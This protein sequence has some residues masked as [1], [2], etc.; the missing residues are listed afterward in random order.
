MKFNIFHIVRRSVIF[1]KSAV[2]YQCLITALLSAVITGSLLIGNSVRDS[3][4]NSAAER[5]GKTGILVSSGVRYFNPSLSTRL[6]EKTSIDCVSL[7]ETNGFCQNFASGKTLINVR[8]FGIN[9][10]FFR[11]HEVDSI[12]IKQGEVAVNSMLAQQLGLKPGDD[13]ILRFKKISEIPSN[14][15]FAS[16]KEPEVSLV[17][18]VGTLLSPEQT[19]NFSLGINQIVPLNVFVNLSDLERNA[20]NE[21]KVNRLL[22]ERKR[23]VTVADIYRNLK[24]ILLPGD[25]G[26][27]FRQIENIGASELIAG[28]IFI[29]Q[30]VIDEIVSAIPPARPIITYLANSIK[31]GK[32]STPYSFVSGLPQ[33]L[34]TLVPGDNNILINKWL[35]DDI[36]AKKGDTVTIAWY[37]TGINKK[38]EE[39][40]GRFK[41][42]GTV[43]INGI[44]SDSLLMP[45]IQGISGSE[46]CSEWDAGIPVSLDAIRNKDE[47]YWNRYRGTPKAFTNYET[48]KELWGNIFGPATAV[49][50]PAGLSENEIK[51]ELKG[52]IDPYRSGFMIRDL[53]N[54]ELKAA[55]EGVDFST[56]FLSLGIFIIISS[57]FLLSL[58]VSFFFDSRKEQIF[59]LRAIGF[60]NRK[61]NNILFYET[62]AI[63][64]AGAVAGAFV[65]SIFNRLI[66]TA[67]N[68][69][70]S[71]AIQTNTLTTSF[72]L[73][74]IFSGFAISFIVTLLFLYIKSR[75]YLKGLDR[76]ET[77]L[78]KGYSPAKNLW[79][80]LLSFLCAML[81]IFLSFTETINSTAFAFAGG[82]MMLVSMIFGTRQYTLSRNKIKKDYLRK[83]RSLS[84]SYFAFYP[85]HVVTP[86]L[87][88]AAGLFVIIATSINRKDFTSEA[89]SPSGGT[90]GYLLW[91]ETAIPVAMDLNTSRGL[92][93]NGLNTEDLKGISFVQARKAEG[94]D[95]SCLNLNHVTS[96]PIL[97]LDP[98]SFIKKGSFSFASVMKG[99]DRINPWQ[100]LNKP[101]HGN[102]IFGIADQTVMQWGLKL[103]PGDTIIVKSENGQPLNI[104]LLAGLKSSVFQGYVIIGED[105]FNKFMPSVPGNTV[106]LVNGNPGLSDKYRDALT[107]RLENYGI[108]VE[109]TKQRLASFYQVTNTY[110]SVF[111]VLGAFGLTIGVI[112]LGFILLRNYNFRKR[113]FAL[114]LATG[115]SLKKIRRTIL[116]EQIFIFSAGLIS[117]IIPAILATLP[118]LRSVSFIPW[119]FL[120]IMIIAVIVTGFAALLIS[121]RKV[122]NASLIYSLRKE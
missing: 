22:S 25:I 64:M 105:N 86:V 87:F 45:E 55:N 27:N 65:G 78:H 13:I 31:A 68:S 52:V 80:L 10:D 33:S 79:F 5:L 56:L 122:S 89:N 111:N 96:P 35:A 101:L 8:I 34:Y 82:S 48:G 91:C 58:V 41:I 115:F 76:K 43:D 118:S 84:R 83:K 42:D 77:G 24:E 73:I 98:S 15:P 71:G 103:K 62:G 110:L 19:G 26:L 74:T 57:V 47:D 95:A 32:R 44:W 81:F 106:F 54:E 4:K 40:S 6:A 117:G 99:Y 20:D 49:R 14:A 39:K 9:P 94:D 119:N 28:R 88:I 23:E 66:I 1:Y 92:Q 63:A 70:W 38:L 116:S 12:N 97:G 53:N 120:A 61:I 7:L 75:L 113:E 60:T 18:T 17:L 36:N 69:V 46:S 67:L 102:T 107:G 121:V 37:V 16:D 11:F 30:P 3:L 2:T 21:L 85:S 29:D 112:G 50:F 100:L 72:N 51:S 114:M 104:V 59:T 109:T 108:F 90:G 93:E